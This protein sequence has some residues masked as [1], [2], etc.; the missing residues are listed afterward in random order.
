MTNLVTIV[1]DDQLIITDEKNLV[2]DDFVF[3][4]AGDLVPA[5]LELVEA[6]GLEI[7]EFDITGEIMPVIK[8]V[9]EHDSNLYMEKQN[10]EGCR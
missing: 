6:R 8:T 1:K 9:G 10:H 7:D 3:V 5:D 4:Q 2:I